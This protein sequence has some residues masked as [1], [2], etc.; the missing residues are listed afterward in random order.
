M[1]HVNPLP[2]TKLF[3]QCA[4]DKLFTQDAYAG[5]FWKG[6]TSIKLAGPADF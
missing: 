1:S 2:G 4:I 6:E 5:V 3:E